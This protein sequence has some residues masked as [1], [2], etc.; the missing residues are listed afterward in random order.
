MPTIKILFPSEF[1]SRNVRRIGRLF[2]IRH[3]FTSRP[4]ALADYTDFWLNPPRKKLITE[5]P[6]SKTKGGEKGEKLD[7]SSLTN[8]MAHKKK[9]SQI[10]G[11]RRNHERTKKVRNFFLLCKGS[12]H[13]EFVLTSF[14]DI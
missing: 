10:T 1:K 4:K 9:L 13:S 7:D 12:R 2:H 8:F 5:S 14:S 3:F 6:N 11:A